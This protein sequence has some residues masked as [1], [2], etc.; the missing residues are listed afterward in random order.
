MMIV[1]LGRRAKRTENQNSE[2]HNLQLM[3][4]PKPFHQTQSAKCETSSLLGRW[5]ILGYSL[6][7]FRNSVLRELPRQNESDT[8]ILA[9]KK[10]MDEED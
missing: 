10:I 2:N 3:F 8:N 1:S 9:V 7:P 4:V 6:S 5:R